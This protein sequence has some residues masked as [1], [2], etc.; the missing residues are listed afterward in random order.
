MMSAF[1]ALVCL[2]AS[3]L[4]AP[5]QSQY[6]C[7]Y[8]FVRDSK[9]AFAFASFANSAASSDGT[10]SICSPFAPIHFSITYFMWQHPIRAAAA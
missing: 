2:V 7:L 6:P 3:C 8:P 4:A 1:S 5:T 10:P 9:N